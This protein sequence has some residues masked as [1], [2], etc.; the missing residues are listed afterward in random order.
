WYSMK[1]CRK[2]D[3]PPLFNYQTPW[4]KYNNTIEDYF[5]R[6]GAL[7]SKGRPA[8]KTLLLHPLSTAWMNV[9]IDHN[10]PRNSKL[11]EKTDELGYLLNDYTRNLMSN[12]ID[13]DYGDEEIMAMMA[14]VENGRLRIGEM[15]YQTVVIPPGMENMFKNTMELLE[16]FMNEGGR[17]ICQA[18]GIKF[19]EGVESDAFE[20]LLKHTNFIK[21]DSMHDTA[22]NIER[23]VSIRLPDGNEA[24]N[25]FSMVR[26][27]DGTRLLFVINNDKFSSYE[28]E[29]KF[30]GTG[31]LEEWVPLT[32]EVK[33]YPSHIRGEWTSFSVS[34]GPTDSKI[35]V[36][37]NGSPHISV[38]EEKRNYRF[39]TGLGSGCAFE[40]TD[41]NVLVLDMC[42]FDY[43][44]EGFGE[45][46]EVWR[47][48]KRLRK[49]LGMEP[50]YDNRGTQ[51]YK[52]IYEKH[53][54][55]GRKLRIK[56][57][58]TVEEIPSKA[59]L[60]VEDIGD[61][62]TTL[63]GN[64]VEMSKI[65]YFLDKDFGKVSLSGLIEGVNEIILEC[66]YMSS[67]ELENIY[68]TGDFGVSVNRTII[69]EPEKLMNG[70]WGLQGY[71]FY[72]AGIKYKYNFEYNENIGRNLILDLGE[73][74]DVVTI[75][76]LN[77]NETVV[78]WKALNK[79]EIGH[80]LNPGSNEIEIE[81]MGA[82][83][84]MFGPLHL[85]DSREKWTNATA[86]HPEDDRYTEQ[87]ITHPWGLME[88]VCVYSY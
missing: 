84:N 60:V 3:Y 65:G 62:S 45:T 64:P 66:R 21:T 24:G 50:V 55:D 13:F 80:M 46:D 8:I 34:F 31:K 59:F 76:R 49:R 67:T 9:E 7:T 83:R 11:Q 52:W 26:D 35:F 4:W 71:Y 38:R 23:E 27:Y 10:D 17:V 57:N 44:N 81:V 33:A 16:S 56:F 15:E 47:H 79:V 29:I 54:N 30:K 53:E 12:H 19:V 77:G 2:R 86:F 14:K 25:L 85:T 78:P 41:D 88:Q 6:I 40:R 72:H 68:I 43:N 36:L 20:A 42:C 32:G 37:D 1:G 75:V 61:Y 18:E 51:R 5:A 22:A 58:F 28:T 63:N 48:Q 39:V 70:D 87:Y 82:P 73:Y 69:G 74:N